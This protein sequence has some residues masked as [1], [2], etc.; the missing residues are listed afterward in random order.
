MQLGL[1]GLAGQET[2]GQRSPAENV[3]TAL[4]A[5]PGSWQVLADL[6]GAL[7]GDSHGF[8]ACRCGKERF[9]AGD[10]PGPSQLANGGRGAISWRQVSGDVNEKRERR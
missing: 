9:H 5:I 6:R 2:Q 1:N 7:P 10:T 3:T 4:G 8:T